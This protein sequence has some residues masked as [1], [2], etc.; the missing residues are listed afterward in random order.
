[1]AVAPGEGLDETRDVLTPAH[2]ERGELQSGDPTFR[3]L[4][5]CRDLA[6]RK[7]ESHHVVQEGGCLLGREAQVGCPDLGHLVPGPKP[8]EGER[9]IRAAGDHEVDFLRHVLQQEGDGLLD[10]FGI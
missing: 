7:R 4:S 10:R 2:R 6:W 5:K 3:D 8:G 1:M 9:R